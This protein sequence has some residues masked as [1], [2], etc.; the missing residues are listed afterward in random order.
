MSPTKIQKTEYNK[1]HWKQQQQQQ[2][3]NK[4]RTETRIKELFESKASY[5][6][7]R[8][9]QLKIRLQEMS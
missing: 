3:T 4:S 6:N 5:S 8:L 2:Q 7:A 1:F 9:V